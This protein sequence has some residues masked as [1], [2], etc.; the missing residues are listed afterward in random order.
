L[1]IVWLTGMAALALFAGIAWYLAPLT[2]NVL[3]LQ[4][5]F[6]PRAF[7]NVVHVWSPEQLAR[8]RWHLLPDCA[9]LASY[10]AFGYLLVSRS[11]LFTHQRPMLRA[12]ALW[13]LP[14]AAAFDAAENALHWWLTGAPRFGVELPFL[15]SGL[16][17]TLKWLLLLG[18][19][20]ALVLALARTARPGE[21][22]VR[23]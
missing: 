17:A 16:C 6:S 18:F 7:A 4:F 19:A 20:T 2:P 14:L 22:G 13:S 3:A 15:A 23:G 8:F 1:R 5:T 11:A 12:A 21:P 10:G 9:L